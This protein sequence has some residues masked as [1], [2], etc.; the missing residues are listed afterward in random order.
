MYRSLL[1]HGSCLCDGRVGILSPSARLPFSCC[2]RCPT[3][4]CTCM[5]TWSAMLQALPPCSA[6]Q[7][8][9][10]HPAPSLGQ[11]SLPHGLRLA[12]AAFP[13][14]PWAILPF[15]LLKPEKVYG[16]PGQPG[17]YRTFGEGHNL[18]C[19]PLFKKILLSE[20]MTRGPAIVGFLDG[21][22]PYSFLSPSRALV[23]WGCEWVALD[24]SS[25]QLDKRTESDIW[26]AQSCRSLLDCREVGGG[27]GSL[28]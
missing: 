13:T 19:F 8:W 6:W 26:S 23:L 9:P 22:V 28:P 20:I 27:G 11:P 17:G 4:T 10:P 7:T 25:L 21:L 18:A 3:G 1:L 14:I 16:F 5:Q 15:S 2:C 12:A 24:L